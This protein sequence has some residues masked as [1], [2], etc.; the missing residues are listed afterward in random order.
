[1]SEANKQAQ[2]GALPAEAMSEM[3]MDKID[4]GRLQKAYRDAK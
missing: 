3:E 4:I 1:V 2:A